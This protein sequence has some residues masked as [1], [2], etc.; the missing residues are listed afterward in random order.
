MISK[1]SFLQQLSFF[2]RLFENKSYL[3]PPQKKRT[4]RTLCYT[5]YPARKQQQPSK[6]WDVERYNKTTQ[7]AFTT[8]IGSEI[9]KIIKKNNQ[10]TSK[11][12]QE[13]QPNKNHQT[14]NSLPENKKIKR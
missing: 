10:L 1:F 4:P 14:Q 9:N 3:T 2:F 5:K 12:D 11:Q 7:H 13:K 6:Y 8:F